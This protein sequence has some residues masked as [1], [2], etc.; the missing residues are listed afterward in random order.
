M[1]AA[2]GGGSVRASAGEARSAVTRAS[3]G[4]PSQAVTSLNGLG[5]DLLGRNLRAGTG[6]VALSPWSIGVALAM[7]RA[8]ARGT[9]AAEMDRVLHIADPA[10]MHA[11]MNALDR[12][13]AARNGAFDD[14]SKKRA[15][16]VAAANRSFAQRRLH[17]EQPFL[18]ELA[19]SY[20]AGVGLVDFRR[21]AAS[22]RGGINAWVAQRTRKRIPELLSEGTVDRTTRLVLVNAVYL[23]ADW[24]SPFEKESTK[25]AVFQAPKGDVQAPFMRGEAV[26]PFLAGD[27]WR[28]VELRYAGGK[29]AMDVVLPDEGRYGNVVGQL[30]NVSTALGGAQAV[31]VDLR[32]PKFDIG[33]SLSLK[34]ELS[35][36]GMPTP[37]SDRADFS[38]MTSD[39][40]LQIADVVHQANVTVDEKGTVAAAATGV[41]IRNDSAPAR[42]EQLV[43]D[44]PFIFLI[45]D[46]PTGAVLFAGQVTDPSSK[47]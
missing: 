43:V 34:D 40:Q 20:G 10:E 46:L 38:G 29:L 27:G 31:D 19:R 39:E 13:I 14:G 12:E 32:L 44:R 2:C 22:A 41:I 1:A 23:K 24:A 33:K 37:F 26:R 11:S 5:F 8:G 18:D 30:A 17:F 47:R 4:D 7:A 6:N 21:N 3:G 36:L 42:I 35:A 16:D 28:G 9:T 25:D 15:V 45:R